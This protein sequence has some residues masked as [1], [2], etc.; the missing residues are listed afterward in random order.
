MSEYK[1]LP[2]AGYKPQSELAVGLVNSNKNVEE[3]VLRVFDRLAASPLV[4]QRWL[5]IGR[6]H[7]EQGF[8]AANRAIFQPGRVVLSEDH[9]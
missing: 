7:I 2:V 8:M 5:A 6:T 4:D 1:G 9:E 3:A